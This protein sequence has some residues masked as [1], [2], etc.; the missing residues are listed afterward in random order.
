MATFNSP[1]SPL[2]QTVTSNIL[3]FESKF[4]LLFAA[5]PFLFFYSL[6]LAHFFFGRI[7]G[8]LLYFASVFHLH[9]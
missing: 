8:V 9:F 7:F 4:V 2:L 1:Y 5:I 3:C 6:I